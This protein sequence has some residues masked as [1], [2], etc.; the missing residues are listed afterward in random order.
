MTGSD[1]RDAT[2]RSVAFSIVP[3]NA[4]GLAIY[5]AARRGRSGS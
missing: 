4:L 1:D 5:L 2:A 3:L